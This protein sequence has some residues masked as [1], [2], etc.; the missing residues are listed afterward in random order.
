MIGRGYGR[1]LCDDENNASDPVGKEAGNESEY[2]IGAMPDLSSQTIKGLS[3][4]E[5]V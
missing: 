3:V 5:L 1:C 4:N 2:V